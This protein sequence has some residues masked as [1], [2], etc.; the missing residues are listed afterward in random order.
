[1]KHVV[2]AAFGAFV[3]LAPAGL[4]HAQP[5]TPSSPQETA[6]IAREAY[7]YGFPLV[8]NYAVLYRFCFDRQAPDY[9]GPINTISSART[10]AG[11]KDRAFV[12]PN[13]DTPYSYAWLDL[14]TEPIVL[15]VPP[16][17]KDRYVSV[18]L[19][20]AY[21]Y[22][23]DYVTPRTNGQAGGAFLVAGPGWSGTPPPG[24]TRVFH[25]PTSLA[26]A[27][28]RTQVLGPGDL[29]A[30]HALQDGY[31]VQPLSAF[32]KQRPPATAPALRPTAPTDPRTIDDPVPF[33]RVLNWMLAA[34]PVLPEEAALRKRFERIGVVAGQPFAEPAADVREALST[35]MR[36]GLE[37]MSARAKTVRSSAELFGSR[38]FLKDDYLVRATAA[39]IGIYGNAAEE[40]LGVGYQTDAR[41]QQFDGT[42]AYTITFAPGAEPPVDAFWSI[43]AYTADRFLYANPINRYAISS[44]MVARMRKNPDGGFTV[45]V[46]HESPGAEREANWLPVPGTPFG[47]TFRTYLPGDAIR[48]GKWTAPPVVP[49]D[50][51]G[52]TLDRRIDEA[53]EATFPLYE[54]AKARFNAMVNPLNP[55][56]SPVNG[57]PV[58]RRTL[59]D[60]TARD[61]T[62]PN[63]DTLYSATW[64]DLHAT[65]VRIHVPRIAGG[66]YWSV[67]LLDIFTNNFAVLG[68]TR[69]GEGPVDVTVVGPGWTGATPPGRVIVS[70]SND[71][72]VIGRF[73]VNGPADAPAVHAIQ[74]GV[75]V[76]QVNASAKVLPQWIPVRSST[77]PENYLAVVNEM[78]W[79]NPVP[80]A[81]ASRFASWADL[82]LGG[83]AYAFARTS[84]DVQAAWRRRLPVLHEGLKEGLKRGAR[85]VSGWS[86]PAPEVGEFGTNYALRAA[87]AFGGLSALPS[88]EAI[89]LNLENDPATGAPLDGRRRWKLIVPPIAASG[90]WSL[91][92]YEKDAD[93]RLF[94]TQNAI[95]RYSVGDR[96]A[97]IT[98]RPD[99]SIEI[100]LQHDRPA[101]TANWLPTPNGPMALTLRVYGPSDAMRRGE[102]PLPRLVRAD[103]ATR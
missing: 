20:D 97:G 62:T 83:G 76:A 95:G 64:L 11:P 46:Q 65:P 25:S 36:L 89:Y 84:A 71:V 96:T 53:F 12:A 24:I 75:T 30:V 48:T 5:A 74:D 28:Y 101:D 68:R 60:Y 31:R 42:H 66:R 14:R 39:M 34:A 51:A 49:V 2:T 44:S 87:V 92:M 13:V 1:V 85:L 43:T 22:I 82:G 79:R 7:I 15:V 80:P 90:F 38:A 6:E 72:Q 37:Q 73:L 91:T 59:I 23:I 8:D 18:Q 58:H 50:A 86:V 9:K 70:P 98:R 47:L 63:N 26:L 88:R 61:V 93:G 17:E 55:A 19:I 10:V 33:F 40:F 29:A 21:T 32:L 94:F 81:E 3:A 102:A 77:D 57:V 4:L 27:F 69:D 67:A 78:L 16:F 45:Y 35:G 41:G 52:T 56:P 99:G 54:M 100:L 103:A